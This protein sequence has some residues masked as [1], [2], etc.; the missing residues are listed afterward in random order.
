MATYTAKQ[1]SIN[2]GSRDVVINSGELP[3]NISVGDFLC[4]GQFAP[5]EINRVYFNDNNTPF[6]ELVELWE[7]ENQASQPAIV[8]PTTVE[9]R[10]TAH[11][12]KAANTLVNDNTQAMQTWQTK[13][14]EV[15]FK[16]IDGTVT[17][18]KTLKQMESEFNALMARLEDGVV[19]PPS[20]AK[21]FLDATSRI[22]S[23][24]ILNND[25]EIWSA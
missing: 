24:S 2:N 5:M 18:V 17:T 12:L 11:A 4:I 6:I 3:Q 16:N 10:E 21:K 19:L 1:V 9:F 14:G 15:E 23:G 20:S 8:I 22:Y 7:N 13:L 25:S